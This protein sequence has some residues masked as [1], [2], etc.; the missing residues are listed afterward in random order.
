MIVSM[1]GNW[2]VTVKSK[3]AAFAQ[4]FVI[5]GATTGNGIDAGTPGTSVAITG[6]QWT[7]AIQNDPGT[8]FQLSSIP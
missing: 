2:I 7:I 8:G 4:R 3:N 5:S 6:S 1:Q